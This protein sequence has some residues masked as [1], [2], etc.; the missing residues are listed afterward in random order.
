MSIFLVCQP[1]FDIETENVEGYALLYREKAAVAGEE[2]TNETVARAISQLFTGTEGTQMMQGKPAYITF[3]DQLLNEN[4]ASLFSKDKLVIRVDD[5]IAIQNSL[6]DKIAVLRNQ[7]YQFAL[8]NFAFNQRSLN[9]LNMVDHVILDLRTISDQELN[10]IKA[11]CESFGKTM[12]AF[13]V[14]SSKDLERA[15]TFGFRKVQGAYFAESDV[16][17]EENDHSSEYNQTNFFRLIKEMSVE[18]PDS[19]AIA[20]IISSDVAMTYK[21]LRL[22]NSA[23][24]A[25]RNKVSTVKQAVVVI[26]VR[27]L[28]DWLY[29]LSFENISGAKSSELLRLSFMRGALCQELAKECPNLNNQHE[30]C[31]LVGM[32]STLDVLMK[33]SMEKLLSELPFEDNIKNALL[34]GSGAMGDLLNLVLAY[35]QGNWS[36]VNEFAQKLGMDSRVVARKYLESIEI[37]SETWD[38]L[39]H[40]E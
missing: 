5:E 37:V 26:G 27:Q 29:L 16:T 19:D 11:V 39:T 4:I 1:I 24:F 7:G 6:M 31:Y 10:S 23:Y 28:R 40:A 12:I 38:K 21:L 33:T 13:G 2:A 14:D 17:I 9:L 35:E 36:A 18:Y 34:N 22:V 25:L 30:G 20:D 3:T 15:K 32:F 8:N